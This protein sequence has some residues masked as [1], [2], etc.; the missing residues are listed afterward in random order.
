MKISS[1][2]IVSILALGSCAQ[3]TNTETSTASG[4]VEGS[5]QTVATVTNLSQADFKKS[6][7]GKEGL[8]LLDVRTPEETSA[9]KIG[10]AKEL[11]VFDPNFSMKIVDLNYDKA[12]PVVI[13]CRSG[14]RSARAA[15]MFI[16]QGYTNVYN[17]IGGYTAYK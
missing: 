3:N 11:N 17:L 12:T 15:Q 16:A 2:L 9:G 5:V 13:Y 10:D 4:E 1:F 6:F 7:E 14:G 8:Q